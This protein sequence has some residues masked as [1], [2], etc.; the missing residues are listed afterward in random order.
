MTSSR[1][2]FIKNVG[3]ALGS[4]ALARCIPPSGGDDSPQGRLRDC[5]ARLPWLEEQTQDWDRPERGEEA[6][7]QLVADHRAALNDLV[8]AGDLEAEVANEI[9]VAFGAAAYHVWRAN[10]P[11]T[12][13]EPMELPDYGSISASQLARQADILAEV[14][15]TGDVDPET[16][17]EA[18][19][20]VERDMAYLS[21]AHEE[22]ENLYEE[23]ET[24]GDPYPR[25]S[26]LDLE[27]SPEATEAAQFLV[28]L[29]VENAE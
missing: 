23:I 3:V 19:A 21:L 20:T 12:C 10:A 16:L 18:Q 22:R 11:I 9:Q 25:F 8:A 4:L 26:E 17:A 2:Q 28:N 14:A 13:Y 6:R 1:R 27:I 15:E 7:D 5:W 29:L 24:Q